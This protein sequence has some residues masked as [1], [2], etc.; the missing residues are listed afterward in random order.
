MLCVKIEMKFIR[1]V[2]EIT[3]MNLKTILERFGSSVVIIVGIA[4]S[5]AVMVSL[6]SMAEGLNSTI[7]KTGQDDRALILREGSNS[8][9]SSGV[10]MQEIDII[11]NAPGVEQFNGSPMVSGELFV[12][13]DLKRKGAE[14]T[15]NLPLRGV[16]PMSFNI[17]PELKI[18]EGRNFQSGTGEV[19]VGKG[20]FDQYEGLDI[21]DKIEIRDNFWKVVGIFSTDGDVHESEVWADLSVTQSSFRREGGVSLV[22]VKLINENTFNEV[23]VYIETYPNLSL[24]VERESSFYE[25]QSLGSEL[26]RAFGLVVAVIMAIGSVFAALNTMYSAVST[27]L[28]EIGTLRAIGFKGSSILISLMLESMILATLGGFVG[29]GIAYIFFNGYTASTLT[30][31]SFTQ[32]AFAFAVTGD[33][34]KQGMILAL[35]VGFFGGLLPAFNAARQNITDALRSI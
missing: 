24:K 4:G 20:A 33:I 8:E 31:G 1:Q 17:R 5:V 35:T 3:T 28:V 9:L 21:G 14:A 32:T 11:L 26:I 30:G 19:I 29:A 16:Q 7:I 12:I 13:V 23:G 22:S 10:G 2:F 27:R 34:V 15:S 25:N 18:I 6:L